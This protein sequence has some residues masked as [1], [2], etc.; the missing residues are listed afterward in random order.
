MATKKGVLSQGTNVWI[1]HGTVPLLTQM[2]CF[3]TIEMGE[4]SATEIENTCLDEPNTKTS[5]WGLNSPGEGSIGINTDTRNK[6]HMT[7]LKLAQAKEIIGV[8][9]GWSDGE[10][11]P[12][13]E[14]GEVVLPKTRSWTYCDKVALRKKSP[15]FEADSLVT[16]SIPL[17]RQAE[18][19]DQFKGEI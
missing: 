18:A 11:E 8:Y 19:V 15:T 5:E 7:I 4:D 6:T 13:I 9:V 10:G 12:T 2:H 1:L 16:H 3:K 17:K 14:G